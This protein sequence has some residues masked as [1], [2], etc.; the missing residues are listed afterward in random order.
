VQQARLLMALPWPPLER[1]QEQQQE[2]A[3]VAA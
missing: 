1:R 2:W 3:L